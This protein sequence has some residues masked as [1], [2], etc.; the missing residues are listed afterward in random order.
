MNELSGRVCDIW[1]DG[2]KVARPFPS[3]PEC[4]CFVAAVDMPMIKV[5][6]NSVRVGNGVW[7]NVSQIKR[8]RKID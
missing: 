3:Y 8:I 2:D 7:V 1:F 4:H 5:F 6:D